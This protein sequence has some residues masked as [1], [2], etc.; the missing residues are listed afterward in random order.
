MVGVPVFVLVAVLVAVNW[1]VK[2]L[3]AVK[4]FVKVGLMVAVKVLVGVGVGVK[5][6]VGPHPEPTGTTA[7]VVAWLAPF[8][9]TPA[10]FVMEHGDVL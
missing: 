8:Q 10:L 5:V 7:W 6:L 1:R 9:L 2:V 3:V 4:V